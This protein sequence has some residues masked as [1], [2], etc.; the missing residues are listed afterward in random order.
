MFLL[1]RPI[2]V[3]IIVIALGSLITV[4]RHN[5]HCIG[6]RRSYIDKGYRSEETDD[7][8][9]D[10]F[11]ERLNALGHHHQTEVANQPNHQQKYRSVVYYCSW[12][13]YDRK[14]FPTDLPTNHIT[15]VMYSFANVNA[16]TG[17]VEL[18]DPWAD[19]DCQLTSS[20]P[21]PTHTRTS[22][23]P[24]ATKGCLGELYKLRQRNPK[25]K[26]LLSIGG[27]SYSS[28]FTRGVEVDWKRKNFAASAVEL[29]E[30]LGLDGIDL[31]WEY[32]SN[33][34]QASWYTD[35]VRQCR[36]E[37][38]SSAL[39]QNMMRDQFE[40]SVAA[41]AGPLQLSIYDMRGMDPY[42]TFWNLMT[43]DFSGSWEPTAGY[44]SQLFAG[45]HSADFAVKSYIERGVRP[46][47]II[48][49]MPI[50]GRSFL[51]TAGV[52]AP[53][54]GVGKG[55]WEEG[56]YD[57]KQL[58]LPG[59]IEKV[60]KEAVSAFCYDASAKTLVTYDNSETAKMKAQYVKAL[61]L[62]GVMYW[63]SSADLP[64]NDPRSIIGSF[65]TELGVS[66][67]DDK[68]NCISIKEA[69]TT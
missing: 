34:P 45:P 40:L 12:S 48:F 52:G 54:H 67:L 15:H 39:R 32:P 51:H 49:G 25:L 13:I 8:G 60:D 53:F 41:P 21:T 28:N 55:S 31:D 1:C 58:P 57:Y 47:K 20:F 18:S 30:T 27:W 10:S 26:V 42:V 4:A 62:G 43:Y 16:D 38:D 61:G 33:Q 29:I 65:V 2:F 36:M 17:N 56:V 7:M 37:L 24:V 63:E 59:S 66:L 44:H 22:F 64:S 46:D 68:L 6:T 69:R 14:Y 5:F 23:T 19:T 11:K 35:L 9:L 50:Y 3:L